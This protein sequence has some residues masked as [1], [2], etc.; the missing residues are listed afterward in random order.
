ML[1]RVTQNVCFRE[2]Q[3]VTYLN[4]LQKWRLLQEHMPTGASCLKSKTSYTFIHMRINN[5]LRY[6]ISYQ[7]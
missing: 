6:N 3:E 2:K 1:S 4:L 7:T 5:L